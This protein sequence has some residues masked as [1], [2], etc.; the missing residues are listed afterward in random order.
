MNEK[1][2]Y[3]VLEIHAERIRELCSNGK[4]KNSEDFV[5]TAIEILLTWESKYP[6][7]CF[8]VMKT[9][10][11]FSPEQEMFMKLSMNPDEI[12]KQFG[13]LEI[14]R[15]QNEVAQ[16]KIL[17]ISDDD[18]LKLRDNFQH[19]IKY[20]KALKITKPKDAIPYDGYPL[21][22]GFYS[23]LLPVKIV[24]TV[25]AHILE[26]SKSSKV[27]LKDFRVHAYDIAEELAE[28]LSK[29]ENKH[30]VPRN[31]KMSTGLPKKGTE[32]EDKDKIAMA[33]K[34]F[35]DQFIGKVRKSRITKIDHFEGALSALGLVYV[36]QEDDKV[37]VS[38]TELGKKF[39]LIENPVVQGEYEKGPLT[40]QESDFIMKELIPQRE[41][42]KQFVDTAIS[43]IKRITTKDKTTE[44]DKKMTY[45]L[46]VEFLETVKKYIDKN[47]KVLDLYNLDHLDSL[48]TES[49]KKKIVQWRLATMGRLSE[50]K[51]VNW[52]INEKGDSVYTLN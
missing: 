6:E 28:T 25:L 3:S 7:E 41:L 32:E 37:F 30:D 5:K 33:Q 42:E 47:P 31:E 14:D 10:M 11:P 34:R 12:K 46:D 44:D 13:E 29:Y 16:Q 9:L 48:N 17:A 43:V 50:L 18:H 19:T 51:I 20:V 52:T 2:E 35:K 40:K 49:T 39:F 45:V 38:L 22:Y 24:L 15:D 27:E 26:R 1:I 8:Q 23:R 36:T 4:Y 21:L